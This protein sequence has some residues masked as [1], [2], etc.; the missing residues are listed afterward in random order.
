MTA[1]TIGGDPALRSGRHVA[2][3]I[4][5]EFEAA[6]YDLLVVDLPIP[7]ELAV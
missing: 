7:R 4:V 3:P 2:E 6:S 5:D 1:I